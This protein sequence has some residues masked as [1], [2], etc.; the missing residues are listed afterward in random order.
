MSW[1]QITPY[2]SVAG[3]IANVLAGTAI[4]Y[5]GAASTLTVYGSVDTAG[6]TFS[7]SGA[8]GVAPPSNYVPAGALI[9][10]ASTAGAVKTNEDFIGQ[11]PIPANTRLVLSVTAAA[12]G[13]LGRFM[14]V[15]G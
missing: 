12:A 9:P 7:L 5:V 11:F 4:E 2:T 13:H 15:V 6:D 10:A 3:T 1:T 14:F 8:T